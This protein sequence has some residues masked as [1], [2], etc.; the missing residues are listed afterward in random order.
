VK[1]TIVL[2][3]ILSGAVL[4]VTGYI[5]GVGRSGRYISEEARTQMIYAY[6]LGGVLTLAGLVLGLW[7]QS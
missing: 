2:L 5:R 3:L 1:D 6:A 7:S 4:M